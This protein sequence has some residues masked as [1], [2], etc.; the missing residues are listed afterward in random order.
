MT[1]SDLPQIL[2][3]FI[4]ESSIKTHQL[5]GSPSDSA[6]VQSVLQHLRNPRYFRTALPLYRRLQFGRFLDG[7]HLLTNRELE[8][9]ESISADDTADPWLYAFVDR[10]CRPETEVWL[11]GSWEISS[12]ATDSVHVNGTSESRDAHNEKA[13]L[14]L[15][16]NL[17]L[18]FKALGVPPSIHEAPADAPDST[19][20]AVD[21]AGLSKADYAAH[22]SN[23]NVMLW[24]S[25]H[26]RTIP[27]L[28]TLDVLSGESSTTVVPN[29][30]F[31]FDVPSMSIPLDLPPSVRWGRLSKEHF[32]LVRSRT[33]IPR[34]DRTL[35][36]LPNLG[37][38]PTSGTVLEQASP[39][40]WAFVG[41]DASL[42]T[43][44]V[45]PAHRRIGLAQKLT[46]KLFREEMD[47]FF[48]DGMEKLAQGYVIVGNEASKGM[49]E[50]LGGK[51]E[52]TVYW[53][54]VDLG[55]V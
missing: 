14:A 48:A 35:A 41:L 52:W 32:A 11:F 24:G 8:N 2:C 33:Q 46:T 16:Q 19:D 54:R 4:M 49:C 26:A 37:L 28:K 9:D 36:A 51:A 25:I 40:A 39:I 45:E 20:N 10:S 6:I 5:Q 17:L 3:N 21:S 50:S 34:R 44:H 27:Y 55:K 31:I 38:F 23:P 7:S 12:M 29:H 30:M 47:L 18:A 42:T 1:L 22:A 13:I 15:L 43:L 53:V